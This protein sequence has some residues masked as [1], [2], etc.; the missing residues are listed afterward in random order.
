MSILVGNKKREKRGVKTSRF[1]NHSQLNRVI[2]KTTSKVANIPIWQNLS[3][4][5]LEG[6]IWNPIENY[7]NKYEV[8]NLGR[9]KTLKRG[10]YNPLL[11]RDSIF[12]EKILLNQ[13]DKAGYC[14]VGLYKKGKLKGFTVHRLVAKAFIPNSENKPEVNHVNEIKTDNRAENLEWCTRSENMNHG[15]IRERMSK[16]S[17]ISGGRYKPMKVKQFDLNGNLVKEWFSI[18]EAGRNGF[19]AQNIHACCHKKRKTHKGFCWA[20]SK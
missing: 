6:E 11:K 8:S 10:R 2:M 3:L 13:K 20:F 9:V 15:T 5:N 1:P 7:E 16:S 17:R 4:E 12:L 14:R 18:N 19:N